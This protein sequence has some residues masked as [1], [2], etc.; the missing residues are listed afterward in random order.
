MIIFA[1]VIGAGKTTYATRLAEALESQ[2]FLESVDD[3]PI[4][5]KYY[6]DTARYAFPL[7]IHFLNKRFELIKQAFNEN[8]NVLDRS[9]Y[10]DKIFAWANVENG[11]ISKEEWDIYSELLDNMMEEMQDTPKKAPD[12]LVYLDVSF[13]NELENIKKRNRDYEQDPDLKAYYQQLYHAYGRW[14]E[15]Y[16]V[17][18]KLIIPADHYDIHNEDDWQAVYAQIIERLEQVKERQLGGQ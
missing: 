5:T 12:L 14:I 4:L 17:S 7:Q 15:E 1:G 10:E 6:E 13:E 18:D 2:V 8:N 16:D 9:I 3:N 11:N